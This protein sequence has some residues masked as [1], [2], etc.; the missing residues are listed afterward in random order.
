VHTDLSE[1]LD[2]LFPHLQLALDQ[3]VRIP[4]VSAEGNHPDQVRRSAEATSVLLE[5]AG[6]RNVHLLEIEGAHPAVYGEIAGP[7]GA[8]TVL[9]YAHHD[10]QPTGPIEEWESGPFAPEIREGRMYGRGAA[11]NKAGIVIHLG[12]VGAHGGKP[13]VN[14]KLFIEGEEEIGSLHLV[15]Y[16]EQYADMLEADVIV[17]ADSGNIRTGVPSLTTSLRGLVDCFV[18]VRVLDNPVH[19]GLGGGI[20]PDALMVLSRLLASL[21]HDDGTVAVP[22]RVG[23]EPEPFDL[24]ESGIR[25]ELGM[26]ESLELIGEGTLASRTWTRPS[27]SIIAID[28]PPVA[29]AINQIVPAARAKISMRIAP[30]DDPTAALDALTGHLRNHAPWGA[31][32]TV[33]PNSQGQA[34]ALDTGGA[35]YDAFRAGFA[36]AWGTDT[37]EI[38]VGGSIPFVAAFSERY[39]E[40][41]ILLIGAADDKSQVHAPNESVDLED[42]GK[43]ALAEAIALRLLADH[44]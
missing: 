10:V 38:G 21:H 37:T 5:Q 3:L 22:G 44:S 29:E 17:I 19:S 2:A 16:I 35:V 36:E 41:T 20:V 27:I 26:V 33:T 11:D 8:P 43:A 4:S 13:P 32:V 30:G 1:R 34:F 25:S 40:A 23:F 15:Q 28:A 12:A 39:P 18:E 9:L 14:V 7:A 24:P 42:L 31:E 6:A